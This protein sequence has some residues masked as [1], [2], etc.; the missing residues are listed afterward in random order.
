MDCGRDVLRRTQPL[1]GTE[2]TE[3]LWDAYH[4]LPPQV[5]LSMFNLLESHDIGRAMFRVGNDRTKFLAAYTLLMGYAGVPC[6]Y[7][8][9]EVGLTQSRPGN[10]PWCREPMPW[11]EAKWDTELRERVRALIHLRR[12]THV[13]QEGSLRFLHAEADAIAFLREY[14]YRDGRTERAVVI[15][16]R[17]GEAHQS[18]SPCRWASGG[19]A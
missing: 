12:Q 14:T 3:I 5:A 6:T 1:D 18:A 13:L 7:Y 10:M 4:A 19:T 11:D 17:R 2:L 9:S 16:S 8:G 15:A